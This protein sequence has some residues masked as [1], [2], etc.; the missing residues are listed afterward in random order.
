MA[1]NLSR[2]VLGVQAA[3]LGGHKQGQL[4]NYSINVQLDTAPEI[5]QLTAAIY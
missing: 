3:G 1:S 2:R 5:V 4:H